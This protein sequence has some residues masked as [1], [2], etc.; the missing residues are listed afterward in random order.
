MSLHENIE[1][2]G[3]FANSASEFMLEASRN[4][5]EIDCLQKD[6]RELPTVVLFQPRDHDILVR[7][8]DLARE[9]GVNIT[10]LPLTF[11]EFVEEEVWTH[12]R[13]RSGLSIPEETTRKEEGGNE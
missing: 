4:G 2:M 7:I 9:Y 1:K 5:A 3:E 13:G 10:L 11:S 8:T 6:L 12:R